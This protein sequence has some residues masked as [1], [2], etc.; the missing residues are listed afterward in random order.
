MGVRVP[1]AYAAV[2]PFEAP[3]DWLCL[4]PVAVSPEEQGR[5][6]ATALLRHVVAGLMSEKRIGGGAGR[7]AAL[8]AGGVFDRAGLAAGDAL[9]V[10][11]DADRAAGD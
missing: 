5:G 8:R 10:G 11:S 6:V 7:A 4:A 2:S 9:S 1:L 3:V